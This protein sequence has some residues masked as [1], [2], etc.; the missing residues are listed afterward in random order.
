MLALKKLG[1][2]VGPCLLAKDVETFSNNHQSNRLSTI[3]EHYM[4]R[5]AID[6]A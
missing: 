4:I 3:A 6:R 5:H 2:S 1:M